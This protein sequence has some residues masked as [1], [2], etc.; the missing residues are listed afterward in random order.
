MTPPVKVPLFTTKSSVDTLPAFR[1]FTGGIINLN[2][3]D[4]EDTGSE[5]TYGA[6][7]ILTDKNIGKHELD[8][9]K[10]DFRGNELQITDTEILLNGNPIKGSGGGGA[11]THYLDDLYDVETFENTFEAIYTISKDV[12]DE[13]GVD[14]DDK[15]SK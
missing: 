14:T 9:D 3:V 7:I 6:E 10:L 5:I 8:T 4:I 2:G 15:S 1:T 12:T 11:L 13:G